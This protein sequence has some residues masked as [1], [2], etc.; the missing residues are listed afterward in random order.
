MSKDSEEIS[1]EELTDI[2]EVALCRFEKATGQ[3][4]VFK[5]RP[6]SF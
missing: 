2:P 3:V 6:P 1:A 4:K 5:L